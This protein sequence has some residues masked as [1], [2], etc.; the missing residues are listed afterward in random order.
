MVVMWDE[1]ISDI[2]IGWVICD[3]NNGTINMFD[4][5][6]QGVS[7][8]AHIGDEGGSHSKTL[9]TSQIPSHSH[10]G[11]STNSTGD[12]HHTLDGS[13]DFD[14]GS[15]GNA[16]GEGSN[17]ATSSDGAHSHNIESVGNVGSGANIDNRP[18]YYEVVF[19]QKL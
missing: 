11:S 13:D 18:Q 8:E 5:F 16:G 15:S 12:H 4:K 1:S 7:D 14:H 6:P 2:P 3:G 17:I 9:S 10:S 19:I